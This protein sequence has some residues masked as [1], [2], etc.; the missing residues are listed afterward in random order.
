MI[1]HRDEKVLDFISQF[2]CARSQTIS[3][4]FYDNKLRVARNRLTILYNHQVVQ[5]EKLLYNKEYVYFMKKTSQLRHF[6]ILSDFYASLKEIGEIHNFAIEPTNIDN[7]RPDAIIIFTIKETNKK[8]ISFLEIEISNN[9][10]NR[11]IGKYERLK[12]SG[13]YKRFFTV[14]PS[15]IFITDKKIPESSLDVKIIKT[16]LSNI[17]IL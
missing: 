9:S 16:D 4:L 7:I 15:V 14:F 1:T 11:H 13:D 10:T 8:Q 2:H 17:K 12:N 3:K 5:R 6:L